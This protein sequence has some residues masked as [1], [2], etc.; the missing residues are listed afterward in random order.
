MTHLFPVNYQISPNENIIKFLKADI[1]MELLSD[2]KF[3]EEKKQNQFKKISQT[4]KNTIKN[5]AGE[6]FE[7]IQT[8]NQEEKYT[9]SV[10]IVLRF[11]KKIKQN[12]FYE[13]NLSDQLHNNE[14]KKADPTKYFLNNNYFADNIIPATRSGLIF[15]DNTL[16]DKNFKQFEDCERDE[17]INGIFKGYNRTEINDDTNGSKLIIDKIKSLDFLIPKI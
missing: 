1:L 3:A 11:I 13:M 14:Y 4:F 2:P 15:L 9:W 6:I 8:H 17:K 12:D 10:L 5:H 7:N 16:N